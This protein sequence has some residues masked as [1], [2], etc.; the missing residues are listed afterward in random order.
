[1]NVETWDELSRAIAHDIAELMVDHSPD[2]ENEQEAE[3]CAE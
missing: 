3:R 1:M 2:E